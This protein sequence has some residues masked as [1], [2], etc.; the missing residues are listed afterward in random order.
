MPMH[1]SVAE[2]SVFV[3]CVDYCV[4]HVHAVAGGAVACAVEG[5]HVIRSPEFPSSESEAGRVEEGVGEVT[6]ANV[7][8]QNIAVVWERTGDCTVWTRAGSH[9]FDV[10]VSG[11]RPF[12]RT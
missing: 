10:V 8:L 4:A 9:G 5:M 12:A 3:G 2:T 1:E 6:N 11:K 7:G